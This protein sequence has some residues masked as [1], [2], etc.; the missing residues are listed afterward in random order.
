M[1]KASDNEFPSVLFDEQGSTPTT[2]ATG[3]WR[4]Y[5]KSDGLYIVD[6]AGATTG[7]FISSAGSGIPATIFDAKGD[8][9][10]AS[11]ADT[12]A[13]VAVGA[14]GAVLEA[15]S[16]ASAGVQWD[17]P[18]GYEYDYAEFTSIV[19]PTA[20]SEATANTV[21]TGNAV[22]YDGSTVVF[23]EFF[24]PFANPDSNAA[25]RDLTLVLYDGSSSIGK[26]SYEQTQANS[27]A[28]YFTPRL[29][30]RLT[31]SAAS[32]TYSIRAYVSAGTGQVGAGAG[33]SGN[34][35]PGF[36]RITK[37]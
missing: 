31:P 27:Q 5:T 17:Y 11:A 20:T 21:V 13:R 28:Y 2:P 8:I 6:D 26:L 22:S 29:G 19:T 25:G 3:F 4:L 14:N 15:A 30:R 24:C 23:I 18:P 7:P 37:V 33:G 32:H 10:A 35:V 9:I 12:A 36:I 1:T 16:G 34:N